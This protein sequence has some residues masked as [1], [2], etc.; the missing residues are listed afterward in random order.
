MSTCFDLE[1]YGNN[2]NSF[3]QL[4]ELELDAKFIKFEYVN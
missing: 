1:F 2:S 4:L 3:K